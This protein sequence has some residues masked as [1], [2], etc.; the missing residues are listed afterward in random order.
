MDV[1][2]LHSKKSRLKRQL[3][4]IREEKFEVS[5]REYHT[6][7]SITDINKK[8]DTYRDGK[9]VV[10]DHAMIRY[11]ERI[12]HLDLEELKKLIVPEDTEK[13]IEKLGSGKFPAGTHHV[14]VKNKMVMTILFSDNDPS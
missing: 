11:M 12:K 10:S 1:K 3:K 9:L 6:V 14:V 13:L 2:K 7:R 5:Q 4:E 8:L